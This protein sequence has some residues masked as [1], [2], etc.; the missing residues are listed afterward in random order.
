LTT[1]RPDKTG[2]IVG[3]K[4]PPPSLGKL[5]LRFVLLLVV[6]IAILAIAWSR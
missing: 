5:L 2:P 6:T 1:I 3:N 4:T